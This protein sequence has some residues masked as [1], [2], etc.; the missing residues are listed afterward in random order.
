MV[1]VLDNIMKT[2]QVLFKTAFGKCRK[3]FVLMFLFPF[4]SFIFWYLF[5]EMTQNR[6]RINQQ[7]HAFV[8]RT[9]GSLKSAGIKNISEDDKMAFCQRI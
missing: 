3:I 5:C 9:S 2:N 7:T 1:K 8:V 4:D 6:Q